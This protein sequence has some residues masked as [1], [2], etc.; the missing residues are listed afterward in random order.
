MHRL[1]QYESLQ[2]PR[3]APS[4][5]VEPVFRA[6]LVEVRA[7][8]GVGRVGPV[9]GVLRA[10]AGGAVDGCAV[11]ERDHVV[12]DVG[13]VVS[14]VGPGGAGGVGGE[15]VVG[16]RGVV[17]GG[18]VGDVGAEEPEVVGGVFRIPVELLPGVCWVGEGAAN[19]EGVSTRLSSRELNGT[20]LGNAIACAKSPSLRSSR[21]NTAFI[22]LTACLSPLSKI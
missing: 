12:F 8:G 16:L 3:V 5:L 4:D 19:W 20:I 17:G 15:G 2:C 21:P 22:A 14:E 18:E 7:Q 9:R 10:E 11:A 6:R 13:G 1:H